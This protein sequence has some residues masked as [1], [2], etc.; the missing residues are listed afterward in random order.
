MNR[1]LMGEEG[2]KTLNAS[3][4]GMNLTLSN[5]SHGNMMWHNFLESNLGVCRSLKVFLLF[6]L[7]HAYIGLSWKEIFRGINRYL[8]KLMFTAQLIIRAQTRKL[9]KT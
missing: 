8:E 9:E 7:I 1:Q 3:E 6:D 4:G 5:T 2:C